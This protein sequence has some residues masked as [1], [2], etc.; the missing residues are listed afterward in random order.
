MKTMMIVLETYVFPLSHCML[1][2]IPVLADLLVKVNYIP[3]WMESYYE[4]WQ[5]QI[6][7]EFTDVEREQSDLSEK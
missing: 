3:R 2:L 7:K 5:T 4:V 1:Q 6:R